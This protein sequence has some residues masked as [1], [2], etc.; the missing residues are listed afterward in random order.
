MVN[1]KDGERGEPFPSFEIFQITSELGPVKS[2]VTDR[3]EVHDWQASERREERNSP[4][5]LSQ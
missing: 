4:K 1:Q 5:P 2:A 3:K